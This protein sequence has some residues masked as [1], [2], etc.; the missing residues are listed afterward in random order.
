MPVEFLTLEQEWRYGRYAGEPTPEQL[1]KFFY[2]DDAD[3]TLVK[4]RRGNHNRLGFALQL[5][6]V[7]FCCTFLTDP[8][9]VPTG[10]VNYLATQLGITD[11]TCLER[12]RSSETRWDHAAEI[13]QR[14]GY[15]DFNDQPE[16][17]RLVRWL[18]ERAT[19]S[20]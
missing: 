19:P 11:T 18:Y 8:T 5:C 17:W 14:Y 4:L 9:D 12:Y 1:A 2:L 6:T 3:Q 13:R 7:R 15:R 10:V 16:H 20:C